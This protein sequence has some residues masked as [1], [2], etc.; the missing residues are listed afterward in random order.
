M[1]LD[2]TVN[3]GT[4]RVLND[5]WLRN[6]ARRCERGQSPLALEGWTMRFARF[7][8][9]S[10][11]ALMLACGSSSGSNL[12]APGGGGGASAGVTI[13]DFTFSPAT[14]TVKVGTT[15]TWTNNGPSAHT[16]VSDKGVWTSGTLAAPGGGGGYGGAGRPGGRSAT[17]S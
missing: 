12:T 17:P 5:R 13:Q 16:T 1:V 6:E 8:G 3:E 2:V 9:I 7:V 10:G 11:M 14:L 15:V 4:R